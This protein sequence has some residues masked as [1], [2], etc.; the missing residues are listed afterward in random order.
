MSSETPQEKTYI[1]EYIWIDGKGHLRS[2]YRTMR[3]QE[4]RLELEKWSY[5]GS[6]T[7]QKPPKSPS[8]QEAQEAP[9]TDDTEVILNPVA[10]YPNPFFPVVQTSDNRMETTALLVLCDTFYAYENRETGREEFSPTDTNNRLLAHLVFQKSPESVGPLSPWFGIEQEYFIMDVKGDGIDVEESFRT[11]I[12]N[13]SEVSSQRGNYYCGVGGRNIA[14]LER[15]LVEKHYLYCLRAGLNISGVNAEVSPH[16]WEFQIGPCEG[17][18][19]GDQLWIARYILLKLSEEFGVHISFSP[20]PLREPWNGSGLHTNFST[21]STRSAE[22]VRVINAYIDALSKRHSQ[23]L[24]VYG[25]NTERLSGKCETSD[26]ERFS[27]GIGV[28]GCSV[29]IPKDVV[30]KG[31]GYFEDRRPA[32]DADPYLVTGVLFDTCVVSLQSSQAVP[33]VNDPTNEVAI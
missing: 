10:F 22:G 4:G 24:E 27:V 15:A 8:A 2:K 29:R 25:D 20:K 7:F 13:S 33:T 14:R 16:Q 23:H 30:R 5:D 11:A 17:I 19:A 12:E 3:T 18:Q 9:E 32:S 28:R 26:R 31:S 6:S 21:A 1:L